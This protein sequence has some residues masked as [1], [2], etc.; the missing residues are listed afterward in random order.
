MNRLSRVACE[1]MI[2]PFEKTPA[3]R[4]A[5]RSEKNERF[6]SDAAYVEE[7]V[8][9]L[10]EYQALFSRF[11]SFE[12]K[13][14]AELGCSRGYLLDAFRRLA[15]F[16]AIGID[17]DPVALRLGMKQYGAIR[18]V[19]STATTIPL[20]TSSVDIIYT[21]DTVEHL[22]RARDI[23]LECHRILRANGVLLIHFF[24]WLGPCGS[25]L[26]DIIP[27]PW[28]HV[29]FSMETL[30]G[31]AADRYDK[32]GYRAAAYWHDPGTGERRQNPYRDVQRWNEYLNR[33]T[34]GRFRSLLGDLPFSVEHFRT[35]GFGGRRFW[36]ARMC[37]PLAHVP[38][39]NEFFTKAVFCVLRRH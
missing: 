31:V 3:R 14:V 22:S 21:I 1:A 20:A 29:M 37:G 17:A 15:T 33:M 23:F 24:P 6:E 7:R 26:E 13:V 39:L 2:W 35:I 9:Q 30:L 4:F 34:V 5:M 16:E 19:Q 38:G 28:P 25:H 32:P 12:G 10:A 18:F 36:L 8:A 27:F 11:T